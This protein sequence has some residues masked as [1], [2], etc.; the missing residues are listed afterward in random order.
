MIEEVN[1]AHKAGII[2]TAAM[3]RA[4]HAFADLQQVLIDLS[5]V[6]TRGTRR[7][8]HMFARLATRTSN[9]LMKRSRSR[10]S[11]QRST[12]L[13]RATVQTLDAAIDLTL[14]DL[15]GAMR[16]QAFRKEAASRTSARRGGHYCRIVYDF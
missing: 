15:D 14:R 5:G 8:W 9:E 16:R 12:E 11:I 1:A 10:A 2:S 7:T 13:T 4:H 6:L 3:R